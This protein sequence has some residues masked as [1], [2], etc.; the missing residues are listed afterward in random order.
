MPTETVLP[1]VDEQPG[2]Y[3]AFL[4]HRN[5]AVSVGMKYMV[6]MMIGETVRMELLVGGIGGAA[7]KTCKYD[8]P[9]ESRIS[10]ARAGRIAMR[11]RRE[12]NCHRIAHILCSH[13][14]LLHCQ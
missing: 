4:L 14:E 5:I 12:G 8:A 3:D 9:Q 1:I 6:G 13:L 11:T 2:E 10:L 7:H